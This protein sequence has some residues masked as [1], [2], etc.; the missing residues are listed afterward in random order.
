[1]P[2]DFLTLSHEDRRDALGVAS[3]ATARPDYLLEKDVWVVWALDV[4][5]TAPFGSHL[6]FKGGTSLS[7][8][9]GAI[10]RFSEDIDVTHDIRHMIPHLIPDGKDPIPRTRSQADKWIKGIRTRLP[11]WVK[12]RALPIIAERL[13]DQGAPAVASVKGDKIIITYQRLIDSPA[14]VRPEVVIEFGACSTGEPCTEHTI[15][16]DAAKHIPSLVFPSASARVMAIERTFWEKATAAH[17]FCHQERLGEIGLL[18]IGTILHS[19]TPWATE[20]ERSRIRQ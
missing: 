2:E 11:V 17:V 16:C 6:V 20:T 12:A 13:R 5:F 15:V 10:R 8:A 3:N 7:K 14:Y 18:G 19:S 1:V 9:H 4:L